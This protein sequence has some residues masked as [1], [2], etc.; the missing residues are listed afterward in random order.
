[1]IARVHQAVGEVQMG[2]VLQAAWIP[3]YVDPH[4]SSP[5]CPAPANSSGFATV[6]RA[7]CH[8]GSLSL[9]ERARGLR[10]LACSAPGSLQEQVLRPSGGSLSVGP[11]RYHL[12]V[13]GCPLRGCSC[14]A[15]A[16][17][18][19]SDPR[20]GEGGGLLSE[21]SEA[22][23]H[24]EGGGLNPSHLFEPKGCPRDLQHV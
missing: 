19:C 18:R 5:N 24:A 17:V 16:Q 14:G 3:T 22:V 10:L 11:S 15:R 2:V 1:M 7:C 9:N 13:D 12:S 6:T 20:K 23:S 8:S 21:L 4:P